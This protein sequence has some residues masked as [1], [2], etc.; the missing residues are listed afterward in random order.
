MPVT[1]VNMLTAKKK[2]KK[3]GVPWGEWKKAV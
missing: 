2:K 3:I 1:K